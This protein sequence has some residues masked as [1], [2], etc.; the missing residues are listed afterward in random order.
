[1][2][3]EKE[4]GFFEL[5]PDAA[6]RIDSAASEVMAIIE[7]KTV[8]PIEALQALS[9]LSVYIICNHVPKREHAY[10]LLDNIFEMHKNTLKASE[11]AGHTIWSSHR[12][13]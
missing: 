3:V 11:E 10:H 2:M 4:K 8:D 6:G 12:W 9:V 1:M 7:S 13:N 5:D